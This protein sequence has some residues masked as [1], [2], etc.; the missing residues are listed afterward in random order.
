MMMMVMI[1]LVLTSLGPFCQG[2]VLTDIPHACVCVCVCLGLAPGQPGIAPPGVQAQMVSAGP[3]AAAGPGLQRLPFAAG[4]RPIQP[5]SSRR[6]RGRRKVTRFIIQPRTI[7]ILQSV[8]QA[9]V[10]MARTQR[11]CSLGSCAMGQTDGRIAVSFNAPRSP[12]RN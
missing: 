6:R 5:V 2:V 4:A 10:P 11:A 1:R 12:Y 8:Q 7:I 9:T 3:G